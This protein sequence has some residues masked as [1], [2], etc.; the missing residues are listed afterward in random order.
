[1]FK[2][3]SNSFYGWKILGGAVVCRFKK[4]HAY[5]YDI[6]QPGSIWAFS[7][8]NLSSFFYF[9]NH[10]QF[11]WMDVIRTSGSKFCNNKM[12]RSKK[13]ICPSYRLCRCTF[14]SDYL[15]YN[16]NTHCRQLRIQNR[17]YGT[18]NCCINYYHAYCLNDDTSTRRYRI[19]A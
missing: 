18:I 16:N 14:S 7:I 2:P 15:T 12:V 9:S 8:I 13:G 6:L 10:Y 17:V 11:S 4:S 19:T 1:M 5:R 3:F